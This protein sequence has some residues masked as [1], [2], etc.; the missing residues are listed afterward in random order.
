MAPPYRSRRARLA[1]LV[2]ECRTNGQAWAQIAALIA[3]EEHVNA[4]VAMRMAHGL[5]QAEVAR[6]W[7]ERWRAAAGSPGI[8]DKNIS[9]WETWPES[10]HE[11]SLNTLKRLPQLYQCDVGDLIDDGRYGHLDPVHRSVG[12][13]N[14]VVSRP[15][16]GRS[17]AASHERSAVEAVV[18]PH[19]PAPD[20]LDPLAFV[21]GPTLSNQPQPAS[22]QLTRLMQ[23]A[24]QPDWSP[25]ERETL[26]EGLVQVLRT[27]ASTIRRRELLQT[28]AWAAT[29]AAA[30]PIFPNL[31]VDEQ[32]RVLRV[33]GGKY[34]IDE[35][36]VGHIESLLWSAMRQDDALGPQVVLDTVLAQRNLVRVVMADCPS[37]L[38]PRLVSLLANLSR[39]AGWLSFDL[40]DL[41]G[42]AYF[43]EQAR[44]AAHEAENTELGI[45]VLCNLSHLATWRGQPRIGIDHAVAAG[46][47]AQEIDDRPLRAYVADVAAR[48]Y[49][50]IGRTRAC[51]DALGSIPANLDGA[52][53]HTPASS[54]T[55]F[56]GSGQYAVTR[57]RC[58]LLLHDAPGALEAAHQAVRLVDPSFVRNH[59]FGMVHLGTAYLQSKEIEEA[60]RVIGQAADLAAHTRSARL[61]ELLLRTRL[62][63]GPW[64]PTTA[65][66]DLDERL[67]AYGWKPSSIA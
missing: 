6:R 37:S 7:N 40:G 48:A 18:L 21:F 2:N 55:Y 34:R 50:S 17:L 51:L 65:V 54:L 23:L 61:V 20:D 56:Y 31:N 5:T 24:Q 30:A 66:K 25:R 3:R 49:A 62:Q 28:L 38:R 11:P 43:Y 60:A 47:W 26:Y 12:Q 14:A 1:A 9:Y 64:Q 4:R 42:A 57:A 39:F 44:A 16:I 33:L 41:D 32:E 36:V 63:F 53:I 45:F 8:T 67:A 58:L 13:V 46:A 10:G 35:S 29:G 52:G 15:E 59:A 27:W 22:M 19:Q